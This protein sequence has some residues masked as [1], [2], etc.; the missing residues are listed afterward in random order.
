MLLTLHEISTLEKNHSACFVSMA[1][2][3]VY[4][5]SSSLPTLHPHPT[6]SHLP[7]M[8]ALPVNKSEP[9]PNKA[10][11]HLSKPTAATPTSLSP[12]QRTGATSNVLSMPPPLPSLKS[13]Q[14]FMDDVC[15]AVVGVQK[16]D[17]NNLNLVKHTVGFLVQHCGA[18][19][20]YNI[21]PPTYIPL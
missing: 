14:L 11:A 19:Y 10:G 9:I 13:S 20:L 1:T 8:L 17:V 3:D 6:S 4:F 16:T 7:S 21:C 12:H 2:R 5:I 15:L 18:E